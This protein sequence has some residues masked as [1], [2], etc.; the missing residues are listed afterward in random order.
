L[1]LI[2][3][4]SKGLCGHFGRQAT[5]DQELG[6]LDRADDIVLDALLVQAS[7]SG[8]FEVMQVGTLGKT[9]FHQVAS[10][11]TVAPPFFAFGLCYS[12]VDE[13]LSEVPFDRAAGLRFCA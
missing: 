6:V 2:F 11:D 7:P 9:A 13:R 12:I 3:W 5:G 8:A 4:F 1:D 10:A